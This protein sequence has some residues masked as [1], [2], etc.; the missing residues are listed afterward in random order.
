MRLAEHPGGQY[1]IEEDTDDGAG[2]DSE[3]PEKGEQ[4]SLRR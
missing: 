3:P 4:R 1:G 2:W